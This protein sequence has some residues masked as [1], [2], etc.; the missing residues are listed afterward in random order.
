M[1]TNDL[2]SKT[3]SDKQEIPNSEF[4]VK[5]E[6]MGQIS[7]YRL[8][9]GKIGAMAHVSLNDSLEAVRVVTPLMEYAAALS[10]LAIESMETDRDI[11][12]NMKKLRAAILES[13]EEE[14]K[15][16]VS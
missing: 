16:N 11:A 15:E 12:E 14:E 9:N 6:F 7:L 2:K 5:G 8:P 3:M 1:M 4:A 13:E 10:R